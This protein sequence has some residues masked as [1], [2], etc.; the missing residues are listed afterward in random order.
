VVIVCNHIR[1]QPGYTYLYPS[2]VRGVRGVWMRMWWRLGFDPLTLR[3]RLI[4]IQRE[5]DDWK[6]WYA[7]YA[8]S[9]MR[10]RGDMRDEISAD[11]HENRRQSRDS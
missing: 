2:H 9:V 6:R 7:E 4:Q 3:Q 11:I 1:K 5:A 8:E 10:L